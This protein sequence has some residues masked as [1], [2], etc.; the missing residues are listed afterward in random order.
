M[1]DLTAKSIND[2]VSATFRAS[3]FDTQDYDS[4]VYAFENDVP[5]SF[6]IP[7]FYQN[8]LRFYL[9]LKVKATENLTFYVKAS[10]TRY[11]GDIQSISSGDSMI[12]SN[13][14][15]DLKFHIRY[16]F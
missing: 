5:Y 3:Y 10:Q 16:Q 1:A 7:A 9:N 11:V 13:H 12:E 4:R 14:R 6:Y 15:T 8:G 2:R